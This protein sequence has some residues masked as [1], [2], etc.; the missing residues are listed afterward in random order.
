MSRSRSHPSACA[1]VREALSARLDDED[2][3]IPAVEVARHLDT[4]AECATY[5]DTLVHTHRALRVACADEVPDLTADIL[6]AVTADAQAG[7][8]RRTGELRLLVGLAGLVQLALA[9]PVLLGGIGPDVHAGR[10]LGA[11]QVALGVGL[12]VAA[13]QPWR[14]AGVLP[15]AAVV[16]AATV[17]VGTVDVVQGATTLVGELVHLSELVGVLALWLLRR[18]DVATD[19][20]GGAGATPAGGVALPASGTR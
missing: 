16:V 4:C 14:A 10:D 12:L 6:V 19:P 11:L 3:P 15:V 17:V 1:A 5:A 7:T 2:G 20:T 9:L 18:R 8:R 13:W